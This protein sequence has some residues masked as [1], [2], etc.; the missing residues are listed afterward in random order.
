MTGFTRYDP[1]DSE[2]EELNTSVNVGDP[3]AWSVGVGTRYLREDSNLVS[4]HAAARISRH[5]SVQTFQRFDM[6]DGQWEEQEYSL[7]QETHDW[8]ISYGVRYRDQR[9]RDDELVAF[10]SV[11]LKAA[12]GVRIGI[13]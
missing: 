3:D 7:I 11:V 10:V 12:P 5:W 2:W 13:N 1:H 8:Y 6:E 4:L 9:T